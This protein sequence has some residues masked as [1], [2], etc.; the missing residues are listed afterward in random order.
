MKT[1]EQFI[2]EHPE[3]EKLTA[4]DQ[5]WFY[6]SYLEDLRIGMNMLNEDSDPYGDDLPF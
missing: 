2:A 5:Q 6:E 1:I 4:D 3:L